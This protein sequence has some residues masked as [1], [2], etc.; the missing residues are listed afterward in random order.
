MEGNWTGQKHLTGVAWKLL[1]VSQLSDPTN[2]PI[3]SLIENQEESKQKTLSGM[4]TNFQ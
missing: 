1:E 2:V 4:E 3:Q